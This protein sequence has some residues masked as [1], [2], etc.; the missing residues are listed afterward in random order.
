MNGLP[1]LCRPCEALLRRHFDQKYPKAPASAR[2][3][4]PGG[5]ADALRRLL[6]IPI[7]RTLEWPI[8]EDRTYHQFRCALYQIA[9]RRGYHLHMAQ[10]WGADFT[11]LNLSIW[12]E[13][14]RGRKK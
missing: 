13:K 14:K 3:V 12:L 2:R 8:P 6:A 5:S 9:R 1:R 10:K 7:G 4:Q 11:S